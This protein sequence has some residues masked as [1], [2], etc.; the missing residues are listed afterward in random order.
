[1]GIVRVVAESDTPDLLSRQ[2]L[3]QVKKPSIASTT[4]SNPSLAKEDLSL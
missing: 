3:N 1:M 2:T 4:T